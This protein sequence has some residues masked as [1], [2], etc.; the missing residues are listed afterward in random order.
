MDGLSVIGGMLSNCTPKVKE[1]AL[2][3]LNNLSMNIKNQE[4]I[5]VRFLMWKTKVTEAKGYYRSFSIFVKYKSESQNALMIDI[6]VSTSGLLKGW[7]RNS[8]LW[9]HSL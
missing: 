3:A 6:Q 5:Q 4:E 7:L 8:L 9:W 2:N 1:K